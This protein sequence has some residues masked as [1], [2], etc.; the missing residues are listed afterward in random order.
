MF[1]R[2]KKLPDSHYVGKY[3]PWQTTYPDRVHPGFERA[4]RFR[5]RQPGSPLPPVTLS[6]T[7]GQKSEPVVEA[8]NEYLSIIFGSAAWI[9]G[10]TAFICGL[11]P[12]IVLAT[13]AGV[14][15][16]LVGLACAFSS[17]LDYDTRFF[18]GVGA[19]LS[20]TF[21]LI[22]IMVLSAFTG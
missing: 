12:M 21:A 8:G 16:T 14:F 22:G 10:G 2:R 6:D 9:I 4:R 17:N 3:V 7:W 18:G 20:G 15:G 11:A 1:N 5:M 19:A 13:L